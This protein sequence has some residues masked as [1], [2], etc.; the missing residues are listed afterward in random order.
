MLP[1][2]HRCVLDWPAGR[3]IVTSP[4]LSGPKS[5]P[6]SR[7]EPFAQKLFSPLLS[8]FLFNGI[9]FLNHATVARF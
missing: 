8:D 1:V 5:K 9:A 3:A 7:R 2:T 6:P 4:R